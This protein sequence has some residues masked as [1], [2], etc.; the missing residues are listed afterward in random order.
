M[1]LPRPEPEQKVVSFGHIDE[2]YRQDI[3]SYLYALIQWQKQGSS[4][5]SHAAVST[6]TM[7]RDKLKA[8]ATRWG[9]SEF[10]LLS[11]ESEWNRCSK[12]LYGVGGEEVCRNLAS[13]INALNRAGLVTRYVHK[14]EYIAWANTDAGEIQAIA[15]PEAIHV[16]ILKTVVGFVEAYHPY[17]HEI[18]AVWRSYTN[19]R[20]I[21]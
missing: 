5:D 10:S 19:I 12:T 17:R 3:Q 4:S 2:K 13:T 14:R 6:L 9:K 15:F 20:M 21:C 8:L 16:S 1:G 7:N 11:S 18:S